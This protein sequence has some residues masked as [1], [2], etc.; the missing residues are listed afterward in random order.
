MKHDYGKYPCQRT[1]HQYGDKQ[2]GLWLSEKLEGSHLYDTIVF[3]AELEKLS[4]INNIWIK[5]WIGAEKI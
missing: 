3:R 2:W 5:W 4:Y 1:I